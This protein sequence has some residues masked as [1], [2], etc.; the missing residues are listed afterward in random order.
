MSRGKKPAQLAGITDKKAIALYNDSL[1]VLAER[2]QDNPATR[3]MLAQAARWREELTLIG[4]KM[5]R[6]R[7][8]PD[9]D[10]RHTQRLRQLMRSKALA[11]GEMRR[12]FDDLLLTP[13]RPR[14]RPH[15][16]AEPEETD[17]RWEDFDGGEEA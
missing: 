10:G 6:I 4:R 15:K 16:E 5:N 8:A 3:E 14:G 11:E 17:E 7:R 9:E 13:Q 2:G 1:A 12:I